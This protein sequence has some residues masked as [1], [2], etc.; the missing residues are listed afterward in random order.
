MVK[1]A[2]KRDGEN[3]ENFG[4]GSLET[5]LNGTRKDNRSSSSL[6]IENDGRGLYNDLAFPV[7]GLNPPGDGVDKKIRRTSS[8]M[9]SKLPDMLPIQLTPGKQMPLDAASPSPRRKKVVNDEME[10]LAVP[11]LAPSDVNS[12]QR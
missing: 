8:F 2:S 11:S 10:I 9:A 4:L 12:M 7:G 1:V 6:L 5:L 3:E